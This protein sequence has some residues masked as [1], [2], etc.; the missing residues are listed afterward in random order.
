MKS[1]IRIKALMMKTFFIT[2]VLA[3]LPLTARAFAP[4]SVCVIGDG[5]GHWAIVTTNPAGPV[6]VTV[7][8]VNSP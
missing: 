7:H 4:V 2:C 6:L 5:Q 1:R 8:R 3:C